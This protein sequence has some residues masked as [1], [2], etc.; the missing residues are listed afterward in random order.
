MKK[1]LVC[2]DRSDFSQKALNFAKEL[3]RGTECEIA[4][5]FVRSQYDKSFI[6]GEDFNET[7]IKNQIKDMMKDIIKTII[8]KRI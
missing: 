1:I 7:D 8:K 6:E 3:I 2:Y 4:I 5:L